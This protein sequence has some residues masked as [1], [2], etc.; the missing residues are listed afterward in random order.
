[1]IASID[2]LAARDKNSRLGQPIA[3]LAALEI[4]KYDT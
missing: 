3:I 4:P 1:M 2:C